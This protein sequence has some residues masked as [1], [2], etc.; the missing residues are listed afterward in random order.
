MTSVYKAHSTS[1]TGDCRQSMTQS[2]KPTVQARLVTADRAWPCLQSPQYKQDWWLPTEHDPVYKAHSTSKTGDCRQSMTLS[3]KPTVQARLVTADRAWSC[4]QSPQ[5]KQDWWLPTEHDPVYKAHSKTGDCR[6]SLHDDKTT[7]PSVCHVVVA[8]PCSINDN[9][10][11]GSRIISSKNWYTYMYVD[12]TTSKHWLPISSWSDS[13]LLSTKVV[14]ISLLRA[15][16]NT[17]VYRPL[18]QFVN[19]EVVVASIW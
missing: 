12:N 2:T 15:W 5:Y 17:C 7:T 8:V 1:K 18:I 11:K 3:T 14:L 10:S 16:L 19:S 13:L 6:Q 9:F 4:L